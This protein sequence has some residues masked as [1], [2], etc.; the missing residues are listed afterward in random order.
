VKTK[1]GFARLEWQKLRERNE[2]LDT[3]VYARAAA[4]IAGLD[5]WSDERWAEA[6]REV[7]VEATPGVRPR[8][9]G[10][11]NPNASSDAWLGRR[12]G[13]LK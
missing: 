3:R 9:P 10:Q 11:S 5:R 8:R 1:R 6:E 13:W 12:R 7:R 4:W 2:A